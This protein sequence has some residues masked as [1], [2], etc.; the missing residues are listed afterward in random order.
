M[1]AHLT[2]LEAA[3]LSSPLLVLRPI[4]S[5]HATSLLWLLRGEA[6]ARATPRLVLPLK[7]IALAAVPVLGAPEKRPAVQVPSVSANGEQT[8]QWNGVV[9]SPEDAHMAQA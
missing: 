9:A 3:A 2:A 1:A 5:A 4:C 6:L 8:V 7:E